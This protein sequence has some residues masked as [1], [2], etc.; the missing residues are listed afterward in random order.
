MQARTGTVVSHSSNDFG[1]VGPCVIISA[2]AEP[3][4]GWCRMEWTI[5]LGAQQ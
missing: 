1:R 2:S 5:E 4:R 3:V